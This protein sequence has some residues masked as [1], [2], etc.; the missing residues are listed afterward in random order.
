MNFRKNASTVL[1]EIA[2]CLSSIDEND[3]GLIVQAIK[4]SR[5]IFCDGI[6]RSGLQIAAFAMRLKQMGMESYTVSGIT[7]PA[8]VKD[9]L[10]IICSGSGE[11][12][13]LRDHAR[14]AREIG[15]KV[16]LITTKRDSSIGQLSDYVFQI[17]A[18]VK[19]GTGQGSIQPMG[20]LFE[21]SSGIV[22][23][24]IVLQ[25]MQEMGITTQDMYSQHKNLE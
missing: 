2:S 8:L 19:S 5:R 3:S 11:T 18:P 6:G 24:V 17:E 22:F 1:E 4:S 13:V 23:D 15:A 12:S 16:M 9:D 14:T 25:L 20:T 10:M 7:T 21:Q